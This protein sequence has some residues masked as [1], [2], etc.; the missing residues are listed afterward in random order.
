MGAGYHGGFGATKGNSKIYKDGYQKSQG[1]SYTRE[2][3]VDFLDGKTTQSSEIA[4][5]IR[6]GEIKLSV[7]GDELFERVFGVNSDVVG[8][9]IDN[10]I[11]LRRNSSTIHSD[12]VHEGTHAM[13]Y[14]KGL[15][16]E[17]IS[18]WEGEIK[19]Y[20][21]EHHFQKASGLAVQF[22]NEDDIKIHVWSNYKKKGGKQ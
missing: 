18:S 20:T 19:A 22:T 3:L 8:I 11:Y 14:L 9:A 17:K 7:L 1:K 5:K 21:A 6:K 2:Q 4:D 13:D 15:P 16:Y 12:M 10:K